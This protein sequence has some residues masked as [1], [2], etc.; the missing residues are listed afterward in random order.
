MKLAPSPARNPAG[1]ADRRE[2]I[3]VGLEGRWRDL[4]RAEAEDDRL[5]E[6]GSP[7]TLTTYQLFVSRGC[8]PSIN[9]TARIGPSR[10]ESLEHRLH[11]GRSIDSEWPA[12]SPCP[13][14]SRLTE[15]IVSGSDI[16]AAT[17]T[18]RDRALGEIE[19]TTE[20]HDAVGDLGRLAGS[21]RERRRREDLLS[22]LRLRR[23]VVAA[24]AL[25]RSEH[26]PGSR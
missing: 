5:A 21:R 25:V 3:P 15:I 8:P 13:S 20:P 2:R 14:G 22:W 4:R 6:G 18:L 17:A 9:A 24:A 19:P 7:G 11:R 10:P 26:S 12:C 1:P 16:P 23:A